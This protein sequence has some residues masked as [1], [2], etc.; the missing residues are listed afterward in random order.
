VQSA[1]NFEHQ[2]GE[3]LLLQRVAQRIGTILDLEELLEEIVTDVA[4]T[5]GY[6]RA[7]VLLIEGRDLVIAAVRGWTTNFH[8]KGERFPVGEYGMVGHV[9][10]TGETYYAP[11][12]FVD[13]YY[14]VSEQSTRSELDIPLKARGRL[15]GVFSVQHNEVNAFS[16]S[17]IEMLEALAGH[18]SV[19]IDNARMFTRERLERKRIEQELSEAQAIQVSLLPSV[20]PRV[21]G[22]ELSGFCMPC[23]AVG[24]DWFDYIPVGAGKTGLVVADVA[25]KGS[26]A[27]LLMSSTRSILRM[28]AEGGEGP[29]RVLT[30]LNNVLLKDFPTARF[31]TMIYAVLD[32][33][34]GKVR[35]ASAGHPP[36]VI[37]N[38]EHANLLDSHVGVPLGILEQTFGEHE[39][40]LK[41]GERLVMYSDG[42]LE[43]ETA[44]HEEY[45]YERIHQ[46]FRNAQASPM[47]LLEDVRR[48]TGGVP[49]ADDATI[50]MI[51]AVD[52]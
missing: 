17:R 8:M 7:G 10:A 44:T 47:T 6:S 52:R 20:A 42:V 48:F 46:H 11:D 19:A 41:P 22:F 24:G 26:G 13:P 15:F 12:V 36:P 4:Q 9:A 30:E 29:G 40:T 27:A 43:A 28:L 16:P 31:V 33:T 38:D 50:V 35:I 1:A 3:L 37:S 51:E 45:G 5:F 39:F 21:E 2:V 34:S 23:R 18:L 14:E 32:A 25:G 49:L